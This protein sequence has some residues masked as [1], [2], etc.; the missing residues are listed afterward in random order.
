MEID[1]RMEEE[2]VMER[3]KVVYNGAKSKVETSNGE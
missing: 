2:S 3:Y 1:A